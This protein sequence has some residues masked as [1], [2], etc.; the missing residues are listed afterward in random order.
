[1]ANFARPGWVD[2]KFLPGGQRLLAYPHGWTCRGLAG[3]AILPADDDARV[4]Q[5][6]DVVT[7]AIH[8]LA[9]PD[10]ISDVAVS[11]SGRIAVGCWDQR[12]YLL[13]AEW[14]AR[15]E[16]PDGFEIGGPCAGRNQPRRQRGHCGD[17]A[18]RRS[19]AR[20][21]GSRALAD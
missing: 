10:A 2:L 3:E 17:D 4:L 13:D 1:M 5:L 9:F 21:R 7:G 20:W 15:G 16:R 12:L 6:L 11:E 14:I 19:P 8:E 18:R